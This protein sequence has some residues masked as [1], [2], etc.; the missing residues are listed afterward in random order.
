MSSSGFDSLRHKHREW[1]SLISGL[2]AELANTLRVD[3]NAVIDGDILTQRLRVDARNVFALLLE[4]V[5]QQELRRI[6]FWLCSKGRGS[7]MESE[8]LQSF[9]DWI[10]CDRC[11]E[12]HY[13]T[14]DDV[15][16]HFLPSD[17]LRDQLL[18][19]R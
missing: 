6:Y 19:Q 16:V 12:T 7:V 10:E 5:A 8:D 14:Q 4:L 1:A 18:A 11:G 3:P 15:E 2:E 17:S 9:P 13:F